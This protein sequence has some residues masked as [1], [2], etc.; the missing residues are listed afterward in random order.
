M[1]EILTTRLTHADMDRI[2][3]KADTLRN[4]VM[5]QL[6]RTAARRIAEGIRDLFAPLL[7]RD[8]NPVRGP[9]A[10]I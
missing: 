4:R 5:G 1:D 10:T 3:I 7:R 6:F 2:R 8:R 9:T